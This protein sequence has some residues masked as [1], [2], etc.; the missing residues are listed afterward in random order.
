MRRRVVWANSRRKPVP[1]ELHA[2]RL[3]ASRILILIFEPIANPN[4]PTDHPRSSCNPKL[5]VAP[6]QNFPGFSL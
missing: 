1:P 2:T 4:E 3:V 6:G 5:R